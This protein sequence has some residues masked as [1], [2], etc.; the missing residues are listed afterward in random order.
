[1]F[2]SQCLLYSLCSTFQTNSTIL[3]VIS[4]NLYMVVKSVNFWWR[5]Q[6]FF[7]NV[8]SPLF[9][10]LKL[11]QNQFSYVFWFW[12]SLL[13]LDLW[14]ISRKKKLICHW[15]RNLLKCNTTSKHSSHFVW[16]SSPLWTTITMKLWISQKISIYI[17]VASRW[18]M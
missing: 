17:K 11:L 10:T 8:A 1:M 12:M 3:F 4:I 15:G 6:S 9:L 5:S 7:C 18:F 13:I 16:R 14:Y 2:C